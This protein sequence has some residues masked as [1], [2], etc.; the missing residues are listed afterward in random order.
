MAHLDCHLLLLSVPC[1]QVHHFAA[2]LPDLSPTIGE[3]VYDCIKQLQVAMDDNAL[4]LVP[5]GFGV[6]V[7]L[8]MQTKGSCLLRTRKGVHLVQG[9]VDQALG[10]LAPVM[11]SLR[12]LLQKGGT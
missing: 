12:S 8:I 6:G 10:V 7:A 4:T 9:C 3:A 5:V 11:S 1:A 2:G